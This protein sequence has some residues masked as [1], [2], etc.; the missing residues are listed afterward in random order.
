MIDTLEKAQEVADL[1]SQLA[2]FATEEGKLPLAKCLAE[3]SEAASAQL[4]AED[5]PSLA[6][7]LRSAYESLYRPKEEGLAD[8]FRWH[9]DSATRIQLNADLV[10]VR[11]RLDALLLD[12]TP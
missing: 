7:E 6:N 2:E 4:A 11:S 8:L 1:A 12:S 5:L 10:R 9:P 3:L